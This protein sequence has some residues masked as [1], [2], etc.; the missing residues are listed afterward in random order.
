MT[1]I[2][3]KIIKTADWP[4]VVTFRSVPL[5]L[6]PQIIRPVFAHFFTTVSPFFRARPP[7]SSSKEK[8]ASRGSAA[9]LRRVYCLWKFIFAEE[10][11]TALAIVSWFTSILRK[12]L[13]GWMTNGKTVKEIC[14]LTFFNTKDCEG[15]PMLKEDIFIVRL[16]KNMITVVWF[17]VPVYSNKRLIQENNDKHYF[18][19]LMSQFICCL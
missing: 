2:I 9:L 15:N 1:Q 6:F 12:Q 7:M 10:Q 8:V 19:S 16:V 13:T 3:T 14:E 4:A 18:L 5:R 11:L 17:C